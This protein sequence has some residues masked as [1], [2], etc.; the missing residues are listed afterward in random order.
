[1]E[2]QTALSI[3]DADLLGISTGAAIECF[4]L[5][6]GWPRPSGSGSASP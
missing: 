3:S 1:M 2:R 4:R 6:N 5:V